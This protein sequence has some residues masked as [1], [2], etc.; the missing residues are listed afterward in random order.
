MSWVRSP[1]AAPEGLIFQLP[2]TGPTKNAIYAGTSGWAYPSW[3]PDFYPASVPAKKLLAYY[4]TRLNTVEVNYTFRSLPSASTIETWLAETGD[5]FRFSFKA[6]QRITHIL[7]LKNCAEALERFAHSIAPV[8]SAGRLGVILFQLP[9]NLKMDMERL[10]SFLKDAE[11]LGFRMAFEFRNASW[12]CAET[13]TTLRTH[14]AGLCIA[15]SDDL[16]TPDEHTVPFSCYR[17]RRSEYSKADLAAIRSKL[18][19]RATEGDVFAYFKHEDTPAGAFYA[20]SV[21]EGLR[22]A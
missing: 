13:Y 18:Q 17:F 8:A 20:T 12:F 21:L 2:V 19:V 16:T 11:K 1:L 5:D 4:A 6:P 7:R 15:E 10:G 9:P 14:S 3:K 22:A